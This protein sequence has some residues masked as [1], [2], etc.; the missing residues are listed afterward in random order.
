MLW[1]DLNV[2]YICNSTSFPASLTSWRHFPSSSVSTV[3]QLMTLDDWTLA[4]CCST[5]I[6][7]MMEPHK[8]ST[9][10][11]PYPH[12][13]VSCSFWA[14][15][16]YS[17]ETHFNESFNEKSD[18]SNVFVSYFGIVDGSLCLRNR[19][20]LKHGKITTKNLTICCTVDRF[21][22]QYSWCYIWCWSPEACVEQRGACPNEAC[23]EACIVLQH[24]TIMGPQIWGHFI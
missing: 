12:L 21:R 16:C 23:V 19:N 20:D 6:S 9:S 13:T 7:S 24:V 10:V 8:Y 3:G 11:L 14:E 5:V 2:I 22:T 15:S 1:F 4:C 17:L 18:P